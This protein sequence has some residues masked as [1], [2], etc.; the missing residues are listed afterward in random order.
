MA[1]LPVIPCLL[2]AG[3]LAS[4]SSMGREV[5]L[6]ILHTTDIH[7]HVLP[8]IT[9]KGGI[10]EGS[11]L[12]CATVIQDI[13]GA[14]KNVLLLDGGDS[15]QGSAESWL[16][17]GRVVVRAMEW[18]HYDAAV[19][20]NHDLDWGLE[21]LFNLFCTSS[22]PLLAGNVHPEPDS[23]HPLPFL[24]PFI[25]KEM[26]GIRVAV[27]GLTNPGIPGWLRPEYIPGLQFS[28]SVMALQSM[29]PLIRQADPDVLILLVHQGYTKSGEDD[30][31]NEINAIARQFPEFD[32]ILGGHLHWVVPGMKIGNVLYVQ[33]GSDAQG[34]GRVRLAYDTVSRRVVRKEG[35]YLG[36]DAKCV[37]DE[38]LKT[39]L[40]ADLEKAG[41]YLD[42][43]IGSAET[44]FGTSIKPP[45]N[46]AIQQLICASI[47]RASKAGIVLHGVL[48]D[49]ELAPGP[50][51]VR[52][53]WRIIPYENRVGLAWLNPT[54][55]KMILEESVDYY[56]SSHAMGVYGLEF[57]V[58]LNAE[59]GNRIS[60]LRLAGGRLIHPKK[61]LKVAF[62]SH[63]LASAG[64]RYEV[65]RRVVEQP[66]SR[67]DLT[68][69]DTRT[70]VIDYVK[71]KSPLTLK[72]YPVIN[73]I[74]R[75]EAS[76]RTKSLKDGL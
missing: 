51:R 28:R 69:M 25:I 49:E 72:T 20:G 3:V 27:A 14:D 34:I 1:R 39:A 43:V 16:T 6:T 41:A 74:R 17:R 45:G 32:V 18:L 11:L 22:I 50:V 12:R 57:D 9:E 68:K 35:D 21:P 7:G 64:G 60:R 66:T 29:M 67:L 36:V 59:P 65:L 58:D 44:N 47:A 26:D 33:S 5:P 19:L 40:K 62:N 13:R 73:M 61:R 75:E 24:K 55:I 54:E 30:E 2:F 48:S 15:I 63:A 56:G 31:A 53:I 76:D 46:S 38:E 71:A 42:E 10:S 8:P 52:D 37:E 23:G 70:A 4:V